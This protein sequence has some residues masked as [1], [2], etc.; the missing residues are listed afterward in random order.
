MTSQ[1]RSGSFGAS[2]SAALSSA[3]RCLSHSH[4]GAS[5][6]RHDAGRRAGRSIAPSLHREPKLRRHVVCPLRLRLATYLFLSRFLS[7]PLCI[8]RAH[9]RGYSGEQPVALSQFGIHAGSALHT[10]TANTSYPGMMQSVSARSFSRAADS[11]RNSK[12]TRMARTLVSRVIRM[13]PTPMQCLLKA[14]G[15]Y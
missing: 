1:E 8:P 10:T 2:Y 7:S 9:P 4:G 12:D 5:T 3:W 14:I 11:A 15:F 6:L 13:T